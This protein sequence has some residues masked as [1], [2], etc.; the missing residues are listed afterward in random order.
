MAIRKLIADR[1]SESHKPTVRMSD[2]RL[3]RN[4]A[5]AGHSERN[6]IVAVDMDNTVVDFSDGL[7]QFMRRKLGLTGSEAKRRF[8]DSKAYNFTDWF[9]SPD[10]FMENF[11]AAEKE[12]LY[13]DLPA[14]RGAIS[15]LKRL[16]ETEGVDV[17]IVTARDAAFN[18]ETRQSLVSNGIDTPLPIHNA[19]DKVNY[20][21][22]IFIDDKDSFVEK[23]RQ[24][25]YTTEDGIRKEVVVPA[26][27]YN[28]H[29]NP[30]KNWNDVEASV[31]RKI[32]AVKRKLMR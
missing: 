31:H 11:L 17:H 25:D 28:L 2:G 30:E 18:D 24:G 14:R 10:D 19:H 20:P 13:A 26:M 15:A 16:I 4:A 1:P 29:L 8:P 32:R 6:V 7:R 21:A 5:F 3:V 27:G 23:M 22:D 9:D 12:G